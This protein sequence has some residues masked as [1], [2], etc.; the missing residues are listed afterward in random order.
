MQ[1]GDGGERPGLAGHRD[2]P[3]RDRGCR[4]H[5]ARGYHVDCAVGHLVAVE[6]VLDVDREVLGEV[7]EV[8]VELDPGVEVGAGV[9]GRRM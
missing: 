7:V 5:P 6:P 4:A 9:G 2:V 3:G 1:V 8:L